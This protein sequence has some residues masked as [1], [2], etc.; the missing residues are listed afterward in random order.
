MTVVVKPMPEEPADDAPFEEKLTWLLLTHG[1]CEL[2]DR[3]VKLYEPSDE[4]LL[5]R[6]AFTFSRKPWHEVIDR[7]RRGGDERYVAAACGR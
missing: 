4:C 1:F 6:P 2:L 7:A 3:V 5:T